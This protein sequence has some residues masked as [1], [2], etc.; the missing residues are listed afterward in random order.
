M[1]THILLL[2]AQVD[3]NSKS[4]FID[5]ISRRWDNL[6]GFDKSIQSTTEDTINSR[7]FNYA[8]PFIV[9]QPY[10][11][12]KTYNDYTNLR[13]GLQP[14]EEGKPL[15]P[16]F[17]PVI[18]DVAAIKYVIDVPKCRHETTTNRSLLIGILSAPI[19]T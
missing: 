6:F 12:A 10:P 15:Q 18:N 1:F 2:N 3:E 11:G 9:N 17:G 8:S 4:V 19:V 5:S 16:D 14:L 13:L 7:F